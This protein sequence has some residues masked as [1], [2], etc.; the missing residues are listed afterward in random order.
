MNS[1]IKDSL[2]SMF[3]SSSI[4]VPDEY[5]H[6]ESARMREPAILNSNNVPTSVLPTSRNKKGSEN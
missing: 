1:S 3:I 5:K 6:I 2:I 4:I